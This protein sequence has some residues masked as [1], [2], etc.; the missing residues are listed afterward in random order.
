MEYRNYVIRYERNDDVLGDQS[1]SDGYIFSISTNNVHFQY[2]F[3]TKQE[4]SNTNHFVDLCMMETMRQIKKGRL[5]NL[6]CDYT[7]NGEWID[8]TENDRR[9]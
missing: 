4:F 7:M 5:K 1:Y 2:H 8:K 3:S 9:V 6:Y